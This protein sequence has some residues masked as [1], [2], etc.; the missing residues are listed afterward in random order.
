MLSPRLHLLG[1]F[2][3][4]GGRGTLLRATRSKDRRAGQLRLGHYP[5]ARG[6]PSWDHRFPQCLAEI[7]NQ[8]SW[9]GPSIAQTTPT[10]WGLGSSR[11]RAS[12]GLNTAGEADTDCACGSQESWRATTAPPACVCR[13]TQSARK[14]HTIRGQHFLSVSR[15]AKN[16]QDET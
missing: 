10:R 4:R 14:C 16:F 2:N 5:R 8:I 12:T 6:R 11:S 1:P 7:A 15:L 13:L 9:E 3:D